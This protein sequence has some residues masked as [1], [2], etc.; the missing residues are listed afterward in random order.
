[1]DKETLPVALIPS[2]P[3]RPTTQPY[4]PTSALF[5][6]EEVEKVPEEIAEDGGSMP[7]VLFAD[8][9]TAET[10]ITTQNT[11]TT[12]STVSQNVTIK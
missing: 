7:D 2:T 5:T 8:A 6:T 10:E 9:T 12:D 1:M 11:D 3:L 4:F